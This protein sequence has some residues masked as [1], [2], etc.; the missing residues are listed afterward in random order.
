MK[1]LVANLLCGPQLATVLSDEEIGWLAQRHFARV[2]A[3]TEPGAWFSQYR[4][5]VNQRLVHVVFCTREGKTACATRDEWMA[6]TGEQPPAWP[7]RN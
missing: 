4:L 5:L 2:A 3:Q 7:A 1:F 6:I